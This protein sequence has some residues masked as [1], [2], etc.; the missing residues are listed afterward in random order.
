MLL[1]VMRPNRLS[2][3]CEQQRPNHIKTKTAERSL[4]N[5]RW[6]CVNFLFGLRLRPLLTFPSESEAATAS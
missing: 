2:R 4:E 3:N 6:L 5:L 1:V